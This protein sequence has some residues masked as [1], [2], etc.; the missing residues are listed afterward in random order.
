MATYG[1]RK[2]K[3]MCRGEVHMHVPGTMEIHTLPRDRFDGHDGA[4]RAIA[5]HASGG[6]SCSKPF[7][8][9]A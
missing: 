9:T 8:A 4:F 7:L 1:E 2:V 6:H 3:L 5:P